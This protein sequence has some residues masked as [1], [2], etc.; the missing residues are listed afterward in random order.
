MI[1]VEYFRLPDLQ[2]AASVGY[3][4]TKIL[5]LSQ[6]LKY[7]LLNCSTTQIKLL[8]MTTIPNL[9]LQ[10]FKKR[11]KNKGLLLFLQILKFSR[12]YNKFRMIRLHFIIR[13]N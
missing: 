4:P 1:L 11:R 5:T 12:F 3:N 6:F 13:C 10:N 7:L 2:R 8:T 9:E